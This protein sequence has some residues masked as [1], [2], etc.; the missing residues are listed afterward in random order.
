MFCLPPQPLHTLC[1]EQAALRAWALGVGGYAS[2][3]LGL[4]FRFQG[5]H[6]VQHG[7][8]SSSHSL[9]G[10]R[11]GD[12]GKTIRGQQA[13]SAEPASLGLPAQKFH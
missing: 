5:S 6:L 2:T 11:E 9:L 13:L 10:R 12:S 4:T 1:Q 7:C 3:S 8:W